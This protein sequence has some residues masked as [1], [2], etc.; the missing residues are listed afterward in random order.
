ML[1]FTEGFDWTTTIADLITY[2]KW[3]DR[4]SSSL[5]NSVGIQRFG[6]GT[7]NYCLFN[8][9]N[10]YIRRPIGQNLAAGV[11]GVANRLA[12]SGSGLY[13]HN[14]ITLWDTTA[15]FQMGLI[16]NNDL[17]LSVIRTNWSTVLGTS[18]TGVLSPDTWHYIELKWAINNSI[19]GTDVIVYVDGVAVLTLAAAS[20]TQNSANAYATHYGFGGNNPTITT[21]IGNGSRYID[22]HYLIDLTGSTNNAPI[23]NCRIQTL[24]PNG[25][26]NSS[27]FVGSDGNSTDNY[28]LV[29]EAAVNTSDYT[30][31]GTLNNKDTYAMG[32]TAST[33][34]LIYGIGINMIAQKT[35]VN[36]RSL[37][38]VIRHS[39][40]DYDGSNIALTTSYAN[41]QQIVEINPGTS[42]GFTKTDLDAIEIGPKVTV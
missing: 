22:D 5:A 13:R 35:D 27:Q 11:I 40:T 8:G 34:S 18:A 37:A 28:L 10:D 23:G 32:D 39:G 25:N 1:L 31:S 20:D 16:S 14:L 19:G 29:D 24:F 41:Q 15:T 2:V 12:T 33:T 26:G 38:P 17:S 42:S 21:S 7:G 9:A 36:P 3:G 4:S 30:E 6:A